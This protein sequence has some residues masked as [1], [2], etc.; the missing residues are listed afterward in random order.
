MKRQI[1][2]CVLLFAVFA[3][4]KA[5]NGVIAHRGFWTPKGSAQNS[6]ASLQKAI[7][8]Q[9]YGSETDVWLTTDGHLMVN[10][11]HHYQGV[12]LQEATYNQC[13]DLRLAN[14]ERMPQLSDLL[15][16]IK[17]AR[18]GT[19]LIIEIKE[20][21]TP[22][23]NRAA[24]Q[25]VVRTVKKMRLKKRVEYISFSWDACKELVRLQPK[26]AVAYLTGDKS[27]AELHEAGISGLD[28]HI[29]VYRSHPEWVDEAHRLGLTVNVWTV[30]EESD[31]REMHRLG[32]DYITTDRPVEALDITSKP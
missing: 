18:K 20:H 22:E 12:V 14:G 17:K 11:D 15:D 1:I 4:S 9:V 5:G 2:T 23:R 25:A 24:A 7:E 10:H 21:A 26:A 3:L 32:V 16:V 29:N 31:L 19:K 6:I 13:K 27:P 28:Y 30:N 8:L